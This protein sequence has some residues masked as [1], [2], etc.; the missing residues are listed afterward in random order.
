MFACNCNVHP[1]DKADS[2]QHSDQIYHFMERLRRQISGECGYEVTFQTCVWP[3]A[4]I[5][6][7]LNNLRM[8]LYFYFT[9]ENGCVSLC[10][11]GSPFFTRRH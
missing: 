2:G 5:P 7:L 10:L 8:C 6:W 1:M 9:D 4:S 11:G 3:R